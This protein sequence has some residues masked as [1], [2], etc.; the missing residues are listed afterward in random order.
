M[1]VN[2]IISVHISSYFIGWA[3]IQPID[4]NKAH[5]IKANLA[6]ADVGG[7]A[8]PM[9]EE[10]ASQVSKRDGGVQRMS[11]FSYVFS[12]LRQLQVDQGEAR[13]P[14]RAGR[15][16]WRGNCSLYVAMVYSNRQVVCRNEG[17]KKYAN[18]G[19]LIYPLLQPKFIRSSDPWPLSTNG[20]PTPILS[21]LCASKQ[22]WRLASTAGRHLLR[23]SS[24]YWD[25]ASSN[26]A[27]P[28]ATSFTVS[29]NFAAS[30]IP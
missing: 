13:T 15:P 5:R 29:A 23:S 17:T 19:Q 2:R 8:A 1:A 21:Q 14:R 28:S 4:G 16:Q 11:D 22:A 3:T 20:L 6:Q 7:L 24:S 9:E 25:M 26:E 18:P 27:S 10:A 30:I 12:Y